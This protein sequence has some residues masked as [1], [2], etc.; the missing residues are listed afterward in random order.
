MKQVENVDNIACLSFKFHNES[1]IH[2][3]NFLLSVTFVYSSTSYF[4]LHFLFEL[5]PRCRNVNMYT[6]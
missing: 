6:I 5:N 1:K 3:C 2:P 4:L